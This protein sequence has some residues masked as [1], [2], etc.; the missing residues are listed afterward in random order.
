MAGGSTAR[1]SSVTPGS[2]C[3]VEAVRTSHYKC[4]D[5]S[6]WSQLWTPGDDGVWRIQEERLNTRELSTCPG[7]G[8]PL[9]Q[10]LEIQRRALGDQVPIR[11][12][13]ITT[14]TGVEVVGE[15]L[16]YRVTLGMAA[17]DLDLA[18]FGGAF[19]AIATQNSCVARDTRLVLDL[20]GTLVVM[21]S[22]P[23]GAPITEARTQLSDCEGA[24]TPG[25]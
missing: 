20:G 25:L 2:G 9:A 14:M 17:A 22:D 7:A 3:R 12:D 21:V 11:I 24:V 1:R 5:D 23:G 16:V 13:E 15:S 4:Y 8:T 18:A 19:S 10:V 6:G